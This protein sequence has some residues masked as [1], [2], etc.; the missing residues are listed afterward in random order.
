M[1]NRTEDAPLGA[2]ANQRLDGSTLQ[3]FVIRVGT[4]NGTSTK[5]THRQV[6][7]YSFQL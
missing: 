5:R 2:N 3:N 1:E 4:C 7:S 6:N